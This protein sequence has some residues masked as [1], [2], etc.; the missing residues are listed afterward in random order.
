MRLLLI[1]YTVFGR[2]GF[3]LILYP[4]IFYYYLTQHHARAS[5]KTY[6]ARVKPYV[7]YASKPLTP[8]YHF[9]AFGEALLDKFLAW[10]GKIS[11][12]DVVYE[13]D[14]FFEQMTDVGQGGIIVVSHLGNMEVC[15]AIAHQQPGLKLNLLV[16][17][18]HAKK[19]NALMKKVNQS[20]QI[21]IIQVTEMTPAFAMIMAEKIAAGEYL[22]IAGDRTP[23]TGQQRTAQVDFLGHE[24]PMPQGAFI[25]ASLLKCPVLLMFCLKREDRYK[26]YLEK[27]A[28]KLVVPR[29]QR[30]ELL[31]Q[32][33]QQ[34]ASR[35]QYFCTIAPLQ[36]F[37]FYAFWLDSKKENK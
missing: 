4:V 23:V 11:F 35:L 8:F 16:Y 14:D 34:Y 6:L 27:F 15:N 32:Y 12:D 10:M 29:R 1:V 7:K 21:E 31:N 17:T 25:L 19:F 13:S 30:G 33:V 26:I 9:V 20:N 22:A 36:W 3:R 2:W 18:K 28:D 37:N 5:S 24:A